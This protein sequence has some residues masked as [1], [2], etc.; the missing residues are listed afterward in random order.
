MI[1]RSR[2]ILQKATNTEDV[3]NAYLSRNYIIDTRN[4]LVNSYKVLDPMGNGQMY[5]NY[6]GRYLRVIPKGALV[7]PREYFFDVLKLGHR[8]TTIR[9]TVFRDLLEYYSMDLEIQDSNPKP[10]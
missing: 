4:T 6:T 10:K 3:V 1:K 5:S 2:G 8:P 9:K 7:V